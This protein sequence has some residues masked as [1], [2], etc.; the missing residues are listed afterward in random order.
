MG[1]AATHTVPISPTR[2]VHGQ[3][4]L[5]TIEEAP[6]TATH[7]GRPL[8]SLRSPWSSSVPGNLDAMADWPSQSSS[9]VPRGRRSSQPHR[10]LAAVAREA[11]SDDSHSRG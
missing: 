8:G 1:V 11:A 6:A 4:A 9:P 7:G 3:P 2:V 5:S 10:K